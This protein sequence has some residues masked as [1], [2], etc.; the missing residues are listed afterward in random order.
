MEHILHRRHVPGSTDLDLEELHCF[1]VDLQ[2]RCLCFLRI[3]A[4][5][6]RLACLLLLP[7]VLRTLCNLSSRVWI[8]VSHQQ[9]RSV[10]DRVRLACL[11]VMGCTLWI[12][13]SETF[14]ILLFC[15][16]DIPSFDGRS[17][18]SYY[19]CTLRLL[20]CESHSYRNYGI[21][22]FGLCI[23]FL[24][25]PLATVSICC[26]THLLHLQICLLYPLNLIL[27]LA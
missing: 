16:Y 25:H 18:G 21:S 14:C 2:A 17:L 27:F 3:P 19:P 4:V 20:G 6:L 13:L 10:Y 1:L 7:I 9:T 5:L 8:L 22:S 24:Y 15:S 23:C 12:L 26:C 11:L